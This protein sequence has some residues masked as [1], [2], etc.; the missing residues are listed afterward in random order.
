MQSPCVFRFVQN[1][2]GNSQHNAVVTVPTLQTLRGRRPAPAFDQGAFVGRIQLPGDNLAKMSPDYAIGCASRLSSRL[3]ASGAGCIC[4]AHQINLTLCTQFRR[5]RKHKGEHRWTG[6]GRHAESPPLSLRQTTPFGQRFAGTF[7]ARLLLLNDRSISKSRQAE[8]CPLESMTTGKN[9][10][11][12][13]TRGE[14][15]R[16]AHDR[17]YLLRRLPGDPA[18]LE[19]IVQK[20]ATLP[21]PLLILDY[22][23]VEP[24]HRRGWSTG[25]RDSR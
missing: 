6:Q 25:H 17:G 16:R 20:L 11:G 18:G 24:A 21:A 8:A 10:G 4:S 5:F 9:N 1:V 12:L 13:K 23:A 2:E 19:D 7:S 22:A 14:N 15:F 3:L